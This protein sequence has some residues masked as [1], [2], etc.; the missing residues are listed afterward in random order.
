MT[1][2]GYNVLA[3]TFAVGAVVVAVAGI[4]AGWDAQQ[5]ALA[6]GPLATGAF[7]LAGRGE[8]A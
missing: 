3:V 4:I 7:G 8:R 1:R 6:T 5:V 2:S